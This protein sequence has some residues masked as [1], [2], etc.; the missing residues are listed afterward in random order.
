V[1]CRVYRA[2]TAYCSLFHTNRRHGFLIVVLC[3]ATQAV[4]TASDHVPLST[5][6]YEIC[7]TKPTPCGVGASYSNGSTAVAVGS[8]GEAHRRSSSTGN[9]RPSESAA[10][11]QG[12]GGNY[13]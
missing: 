1:G 5:Y 11:M 10:G 13:R 8:N 7:V 2:I 12:G 3:Y 9:G 4:N 6:D